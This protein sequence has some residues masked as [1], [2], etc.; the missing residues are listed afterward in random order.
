LGP[1]FASLNL[2]CVFLAVPQ[3]RRGSRK[4][5][6]DVSVLVEIMVDLVTP[7]AVVISRQARHAWE[8]AEHLLQE[9]LEKVV[10]KDMVLCS[11][12][13]EVLERLHQIPEVF[14]VNMGAADAEQLCG[15]EIHCCFGRM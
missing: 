13:A 5:V 4:P 10:V 14:K 1:F 15:P 11:T 7:P 8:G 3:R 2:D 9:G 12:D 6:G